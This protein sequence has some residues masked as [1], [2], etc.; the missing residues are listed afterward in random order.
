MTRTDSEEM[1]SMPAG[2]AETDNLDRKIRF[3]QEQ[4]AK[5]N[6]KKK[7]DRKTDGYEPMMLETGM[8]RDELKAKLTRFREME[9]AGITLFKFRAFGLYKMSDREAMDT[10][11]LMADRYGEDDIRRCR[12]QDTRL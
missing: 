5:R 2:A 4:V 9:I 6:K 11:F 12:R 1:T 7:K 8:S 10:L 3:S